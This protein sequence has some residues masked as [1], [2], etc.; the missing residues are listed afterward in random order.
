[1]WNE[2]LPF[3]IA[4]TT[5]VSEGAVTEMILKAVKVGFFDGAMFDRHKILTSRGIQKRYMTVVRSGKLKRDGIID[6]YNL[7]DNSEVINDSSE[8]TGESSEEIEES[9][10]ESTQSKVKH[11]KGEESKVDT[12]ALLPETAD[13][14]SEPEPEKPVK[15]T[16]EQA[17]RAVCKERGW[18]AADY[19]RKKIL[20]HTP[21]FPQ[22]RKDKQEETV[23]RWARDIELLLFHD[24]VDFEEFKQILKF[25]QNDPFWQKNILSGRKLRE[26][27]GDLLVRLGGE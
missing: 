17:R 3:V 18:Q 13:A 1:L 22:L 26:R 21:N 7:L 6:E 9:S 4:E 19:M 5:G 2:D 12:K 16:A 10:E 24:G 20:G 8:E 23:N 25:S 11:S 14:P 27:Y 15:L